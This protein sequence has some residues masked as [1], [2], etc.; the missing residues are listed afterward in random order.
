MVTAPLYCPLCQTEYADPNATFCGNEGGRLRPVAER[1]AHLIGEVLAVMEETDVDAVKKNFS[2]IMREDGDVKRVIEKPRH[3]PNML[4]GCGLYLFDL[5]IFDAIRRTPRTAMRD[6]YE[7]T[8]SIQI[9]IND[10]YVTHHHPIA[11]R[12]LNLTKPAQADLAEHHALERLVLEERLRHGRLDEGI[13]R[14][15]LRVQL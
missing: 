7:I 14:V 8:D 6:E 3:P 5:P 2:V 12:D 4:K 10:G 1:G 9:L 15:R 11:E 13:R